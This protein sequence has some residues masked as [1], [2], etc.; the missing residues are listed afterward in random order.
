MVANLALLILEVLLLGGAVLVLHRLSPRYGLIPLIAF[1][2]G[3]TVM[4]QAAN[5]T[6]V[7][8]QL[9]PDFYVVIAAAIC[10]PTILLAVLILYVVEGTVPARL[11]I[12][13][14]LGVNVMYLLLFLSGRLHLSL[15]GG[16]S[17]M[18][19]TPDSPFISPDL[20]S[21]LASWTAFAADL[22]IIAIVYQ[23]IKNHAPRLPGWIGPGLALMISLWSDTILYQVL[24]YGVAPDFFALIADDLLGKTMVGLVLW[25][26]AAFYLIRVAPRPPSFRGVENRPTFDLLFGPSSGMDAALARSEAA[27]RESEDKFHSIFEQSSDSIVLCNEEGRIIAWNQAAEQMTGLTSTEA[28]GQYLWDIQFRLLPEAQATPTAYERARS[29]MEEA[30][31]TGQASWLNHLLEGEI[32]DPAGKRRY[33]QQVAS[34]IRTSK[35]FMISNITRDITERK[36]TEEELRSNQARLQAIFDNVAVGISATSLDGR[37]LQV[38]DAW[39]QMFGYRREETH[40]LTYLDTTVPGYLEE[41]RRR[42][43]SLVRNEVR[44]YRYEKELIRKDGSVFWGDVSVNSIYNL[45]GQ[46]EATIAVISDVTER[47]RAEAA[48]RASEALYQSLVEILPMSV[49]RKDLAGRFTFVNHRYCSEFKRPVSEIIGK[50]D[51]DLHPA[52]LAEKYQQDDRAVIAG[53]QT[54]EMVEEHEPLG[55]ERTYVQVFKSPVFDAQGQAAGIQ[56]VFWD[57]T[58]RRRAEQQIRQQAARA[59]ALAELSQLLTQVGQDY[60]QVLDVVVRRCAELIGDGAS[61]FLYD[62]ARPWFELAAVYNPNP[63]AVQIFRE[64]MLANPVATDEGAYGHVLKTGQSVLIPFVSLEQLLAEAPPERQGYYQKLPLYSAMFAPL[65]AQGKILGVLGLGRHAPGKSYSPEDLTFLQNIAD[66]SA[67]AL[68]NSRLYGELQQELIKRQQLI[69]ELETKN[70]ELERFTYTVSHDLKSPLVTITGFLGYLQKDAVSGDIDKLKADMQRIATAAGKMQHLLND[71]LELSRIGRI[72]NPPE[73]IPFEVIVQDAL[74]AVAGPLAAR[75]VHV[76]IAADLPTVYGDRVRLVEVVQ[77]LIDNACKFMGDQPR[78]RISIGQHVTD[79][80]DR[81]IIFVRDNGIGI[82][83]QYQEK[84]FGLFDKLDPKSEGTGIG[85]ALVRRIVEV[86]GGRIWVE[87]AGAATGSTFH[88]TLPVRPIDLP[89]EE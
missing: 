61:V 55:G 88:F 48:V 56:I 45:Q 22:F 43:E 33:F 11:T 6:L 79:E 40:Q 35:G 83:P 14:I 44:A 31:Q 20:T 41:S 7:Y 85:L 81:P 50:T 5:M 89:S 32:R 18:G 53:G 21:A 87:S 19:L 3:L 54:V 30:L 86:H 84:V 67:L 62:P 42:F 58:E 15:A 29:M 37:Y 8:I 17:F 75:Q 49:C 47:K 24:T 65:Q 46:I 36:R 25:P 28:V 34:L 10:V 71:L 76:E 9:S 4:V 23:G 12:F 59:Q 16:G 64:H 38:N 60:R 74:E 63:E 26:L 82:E 2:I 80:D 78:P 1:T 39:Q 77:N 73:A 51:F 57:I 27:L 70:A 52:E 69:G 72:M 66:R 68:L 13:S